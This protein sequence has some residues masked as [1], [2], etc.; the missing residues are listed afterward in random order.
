MNNKKIPNMFLTICDKHQIPLSINHAS[1]VFSE[2]YVGKRL[3]NVPKGHLY[4][5]CDVLYKKQSWLPDNFKPWLSRRYLALC[6]SEAY[7][8]AALLFELLTAGLQP[9]RLLHQTG[10]THTNTD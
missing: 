3:Q 9:T 4:W 8:L 6:Y 1:I 5:K 7:D 10:D 2:L